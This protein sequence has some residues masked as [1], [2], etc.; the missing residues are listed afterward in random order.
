[1]GATHT[2]AGARVEQ[3]RRGQKGAQAHEPHREYRSLWGS[4][5]F[6]KATNLMARVNSTWISIRWRGVRGW[7]LISVLHP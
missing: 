2:E 4:F 1:M 3:G 5:T 6:L 7:G